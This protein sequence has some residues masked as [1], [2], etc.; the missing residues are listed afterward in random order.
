MICDVFHTEETIVAQ[1]Q[2]ITTG[3]CEARK[4]RDEEG[5]IQ[6]RII[7]LHYHL[8]HLNSYF[9]MCIVGLLLVHK[10]SFNQYTN[11]DLH[12]YCERKSG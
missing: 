8:G 2:K 9:F 10:Q 12:S 6:V 1:L 5:S 3:E 7:E 11:I 4:R